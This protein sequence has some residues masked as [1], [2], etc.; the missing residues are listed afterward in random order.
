MQLQ[1]CLPFVL[2]YLYKT[3]I[4]SIHVYSKWQKF[5]NDPDMTMSSCLKFLK[6]SYFC[7]LSLMTPFF[8]YITWIAIKSVIAPGEEKKKSYFKP[9]HF[10]RQIISVHVFKLYIFIYI[11]CVIF[12]KY[13]YYFCV[14]F[15][16]YNISAHS[17]ERS[18]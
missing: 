3:T 5:Q 1:H 8:F 17:F 13:Y 16:L 7:I 15:I 4:I 14:K 6:V 12:A 18:M 11:Q 9:M 2:K 10:S